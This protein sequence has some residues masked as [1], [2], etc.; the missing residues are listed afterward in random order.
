MLLCL[1]AG[2]GLRTVVLQAGE[3]FPFVEE[4][5][6]SWLTVEAVQLS[7]GLDLYDLVQIAF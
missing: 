3:L 1:V 4:C 5:E 2:S 6:V 7:V